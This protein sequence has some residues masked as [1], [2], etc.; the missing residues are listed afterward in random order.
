MPRK[1]SKMTS[2]VDHL[3]FKAEAAYKKG[4]YQTAVQYLRQAL[5]RNPQS[6]FH[7]NNLGLSLANCGYTDEAESL[8][9]RAL[10][11]KPDFPEALNNLGILL[12]NQE[13]FDEAK[14]CFEMAVAVNPRFYQAINCL[15]GIRRY[16][17]QFE[18]AEKLYRSV[19]EIN[20]QYIDALLNLA[21]MLKDV[22][23]LD[24]SLAFCRH[25]RSL[26]PD[27]PVILNKLGI[28]LMEKKDY[29]E[30]ESVFKK[31]LETDPRN[32]DVLCNLGVCFR[33]IDR[34]EEAIRYMEQAVEADPENVAAYTNVAQTLANAGRIDESIAS[35]R[36]ALR[37][38]PSSP[39]PY[40]KLAKTL[41]GKMADEDIAAM[42]QLA[43][44]PVLSLKDRASLYY[45]LAN[46]Y[47]ARQ[48][49]AQAAEYAHKA[50]DYAE[51]KWRQVNFVYRP[52]GFRKIIDS[53]IQFFTPAYFEKVKGWGDPTRAPVFIVGMPRSGTTLTEQIL[54]AHP[55][56][57]GAG[58]LQLVQWDVEHIQRVFDRK[59]IIECFR[60]MTPDL[61]QTMASRHLE[62]LRTYDAEADHIVDKMPYNYFHIGLIYTLFPNAK[63]IHC[64]RDLRDV[65]V[66]IW[67]TDFE[68]VFWA[69]SIRNITTR[70]EEYLRMMNWWRRVFPGRIYDI[71]YEETV[72]D[73]EPTARR[74][75]DFLDLEWDDACLN[76]HMV[77]RPVKTASVIQVRQPVYQK[78]VNRW[79][80]Y[81]ELIPELFRVT[82][83]SLP[84]AVHAPPSK[85]AKPKRRINNLSELGIVG[86]DL[87]V[88]NE[89]MTNKLL[90]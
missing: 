9:R 40:A 73:L 45:G 80:H 11:L 52:E 32:S 55:R 5:A 58:E 38:D 44:S 34:V 36:H 18:E 70:F 76:P 87:F 90:F 48:E 12:S 2:K 66:S 16:E 4:D 6:P 28:I 14:P 13:R 60:L 49:Y 20:G 8:Y 26:Q 82:Q 41:K 15:A 81:Q 42:K 23:R 47:D 86:S 88:G 84:A 39:Q 33:S 59:S 85:H 7:C 77:N 69:S 30:A 51:Q 78:A 43:T 72:A 31:A 35:Y 46:I 75:V 63:I 21:M 56:V 71:D 19:L 64:R 25:A 89:S 62:R 1:R 50:N 79:Q 29:V 67:L 22:G 10:K 65:A 74:L 17:Q 24:E 57:C 53:V 54:A 61:V 83:D 27:D 68:D 3:S 37:L